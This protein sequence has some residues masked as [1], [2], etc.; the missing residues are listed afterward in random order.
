MKKETLDKTRRMMTL[1]LISAGVLSPAAVHGQEWARR[2]GQAVDI[3]RRLERVNID[4]D[5]EIEMGEGLY[6]TLIEGSGGRYR[7]SAVQG[8]VQGVAAPIFELSAR[9]RFAW[10]IVVLDN[11]EVNAWA[12][13][14]GKLAVNKG[15][16][17]YAAT[18]DELAAVLAHEVGHAELSHVRREMRKKGFYSELSGAATSAAID[19]ID[20][21]RIDTA[22]VALQGP[23]YSLVTSG[24]SRDSEDEADQHI[25]SVFAQTGHDVGRGVEFFNTLLELAPRDGRRRTSLFSGHPETRARIDRILETAPESSG[26]AGQAS[27]AFTDIKT[28]FPTRQ[29][30]M[31]NPIGD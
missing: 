1:G 2:L 23:M 18:E 26:A 31:R 9:D 29:S 12:L 5:D 30:Y 13:P 21:N 16:L 4:E 20:D 7:N 27:Q 25:V 14:G 17:R 15:L 24:Y 6:E 8:A 11:N 22:L 3:V 10:E 19:A 28:A